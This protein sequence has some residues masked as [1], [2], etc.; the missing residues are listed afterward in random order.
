MDNAMKKKLYIQPTFELIP[1]SS[2][3]A[4]C[5]GIGGSGSDAEQHG[6]APHHTV[7]F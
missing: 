2:E 6:R 3:T 1:F 4:L 7:V 5:L